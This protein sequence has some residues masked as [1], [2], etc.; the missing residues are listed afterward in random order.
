MLPREALIPGGHRRSVVPAS[1]PSGFGLMP[2][3]TRMVSEWRA[4]A[5][6][7]RIPSS[8]VEAM[9][10]AFEHEDQRLARRL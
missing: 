8:E 4:L 9:K 10:R 3:Y 2:T 1:R 5:P 6:G 7:L